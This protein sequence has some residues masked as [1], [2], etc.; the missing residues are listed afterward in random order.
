[1]LRFQFVAIQSGGHF[2]A[3][4]FHPQVM[5]FA[6]LYLKRQLRDRVRRLHGILRDAQAVGI[7]DDAADMFV[8]IT[9]DEEG[10]RTIEPELDLDRRGRETDLVM[11]DRD[12]FFL[13][14]IQHR[15]DTVLGSP[16]ALGN[17]E[18][19]S[20]RFYEVR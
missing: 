7:H 8:R 15:Q 2:L 3:L 16:P 14:Q 20:E 18:G 19:I 11:Q 1:M 12:V 17:A 5:P 13:G 4:P 10:S 6:W 9:T